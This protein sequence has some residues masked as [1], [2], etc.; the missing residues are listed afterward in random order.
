MSAL[1]ALGPFEH[2]GLVTSHLFKN[3]LIHVY[4]SLQQA[5]AIATLN[6]IN[7]PQQDKTVVSADFSIYIYIYIYIY[8]LPCI[9]IYYITMYLYILYYHVYINAIYSVLLRNPYTA[10]EQINTT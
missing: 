8:I 9:Y 7:T 6:Y 5:G 4:V 10:V 2:S 1:S 3:V